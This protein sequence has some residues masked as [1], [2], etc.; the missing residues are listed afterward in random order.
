MI[1]E[2]K[3]EPDLELID[4]LEE[5]LDMAR[6]GDLQGIAMARLYRNGQTANGWAGMKDRNTKAKILGEMRIM[7]S[8]L[9]IDI[10]LQ[11][12]DES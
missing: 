1:T 8:E 9:L 4:Y 6:S 10:A 11:F 3:P 2:I 5:L 12:A 7:E